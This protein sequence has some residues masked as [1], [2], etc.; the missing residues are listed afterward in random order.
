MA[1]RESTFA[2]HQH[3]MPISPSPAPFAAD[4]NFMNTFLATRFTRRSLCVICN[5]GAYFKKSGE[6]NKE[7]AQTLLNEVKGQESDIPL[8]SLP[9]S[10][11]LLFDSL[12]CHSLGGVSRGE[13]R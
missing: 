13:E 5:P 9:G 4:S 10:C 3:P 12:K 6:I 1:S 11:I 8:D 7:I 2:R